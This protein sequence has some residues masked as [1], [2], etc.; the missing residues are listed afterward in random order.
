MLKQ[1]LQP[2][3][4]T[5]DRAI[6]CETILVVKEQHAESIPGEQERRRSFN[7]GEVPR[8]VEEAERGDTTASCSFLIVSSVVTIVKIM[9]CNFFLQ[10]SFSHMDINTQITALSV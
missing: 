3:P 4:Q 5:Q 7:C 9:F 10:T 8:N 6:L 1:Y 2:K